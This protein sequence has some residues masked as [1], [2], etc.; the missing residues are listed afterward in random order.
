RVDGGAG[1]G[2]TLAAIAWGLLPH[3]E[4]CD[5]TVEDSAGD[6]AGCVVGLRSVEEDDDL[7]AWGERLRLILECVPRL[8]GGPGVLRGGDLVVPLATRLARGV[9]RVQDRLEDA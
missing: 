6:E 5:V 2:P 7:L 8:R 3:A 4:S 9:D 1:C